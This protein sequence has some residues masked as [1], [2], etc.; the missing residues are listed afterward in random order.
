MI[1][2]ALTAIKITVLTGAVII[3]T[4]T[5][6]YVSGLRADLQESQQNVRTL[7]SSIDEQQNLIEQMKRD[8]ELISSLR[9]DLDRLRKQQ[10]EESAA[11]EDRFNE[12][13]AGDNR[14]IGDL[15]SRRPGLVSNIITKASNDAM[16]CIEIA[17]GAEITEEERNAIRKSQINSECPSLAN[18]SYFSDG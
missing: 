2:K 16:R 18:P 3:V 7:E 12:N 11:L 17:S 4:G 14:D 6:W 15:A 1:V 5:F 13:S 8:Q 10:R 9:D